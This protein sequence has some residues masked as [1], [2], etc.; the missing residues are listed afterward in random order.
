[1]LP[2]FLAYWLGLGSVSRASRTGHKIVRKGQVQQAG[3]RRGRAARDPHVGRL[4]VQVAQPA[5][6]HLRERREQLARDAAH[7][8]ARQ[9]ARRLV[10][11]L[12]QRAAL[13]QEPARQTGTSSGPDAMR[14][15]SRATPRP[16]SLHAR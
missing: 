1:M 16:G 2:C 4:H 8:R 5:R 10:Q 14:S 3:A 11:Q 9:R 12:A 15:T 13:P 7:E 6:V